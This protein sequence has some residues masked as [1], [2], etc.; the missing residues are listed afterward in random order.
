MTQ[1]LAFNVQALGVEVD[2]NE[3]PG[4]VGKFENEACDRYAVVVELALSDSPAERSWVTRRIF[5]EVRYRHHS[6]AGGIELE[7]W[8]CLGDAYAS[9]NERGNQA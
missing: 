2:A 1:P 3:L 6:V 8:F 4:A 5:V 9:S 7:R